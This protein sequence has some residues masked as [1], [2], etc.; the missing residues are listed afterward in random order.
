VGARGRDSP[1]PPDHV[2]VLIVGAGFSGLGAAITLQK[3]GYTDFLVVERGNNVGGT[4]RVNTYPGAACDVPSH[5]YS[6][7]FALNPNWTRSYSKQPEIEAYLQLVAREHRVLDKHRFGCDVR[8]IRWNESASR[9]QVSTS[10]GEFTANFV[11][12]RWGR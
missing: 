6:F 1:G 4:W 11:V 3:D 8:E 12:S 5:L 10:Q 7:S 9:W 2:G